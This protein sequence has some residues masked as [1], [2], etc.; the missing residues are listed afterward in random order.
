M[1]ESKSP[2]LSEKKSPEPW[3]DPEKKEV[4]APVQFF[5]TKQYKIDGKEGEPSTKEELLSVQRFATEPARV[6]V[7]LGLTLN[8]GNYE[9]ARISVSLTVPC[10]REE[11]HDAYA[12]A[13][14]WVIERVNQ[15]RDAIK[16]NKD[17]DII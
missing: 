8:L 10:Y 13:R 17:T 16:E 7:E 6:A 12:F 5:V 9:S 2:K 15:E 3:Q 1:A 14:K 4:L 11:A